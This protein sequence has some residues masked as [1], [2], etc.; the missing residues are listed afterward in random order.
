MLTRDITGL[1]LF[2]DVQPLEIEGNSR[3]KEAEIEDSSHI[4]FHV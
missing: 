4:P 3:V 2:S 1:L